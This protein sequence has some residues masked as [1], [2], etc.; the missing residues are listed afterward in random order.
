MITRY[1]CALNGVSLDSLDA[2]IHI[3][4]ITE[5][6]PQQRIVTASSAGHGLHVL[7]RVRERISVKISFLIREYDTVRRR[8]VLQRVFAWANG[9]G[10]LTTGDRPGQQLTVL[11]DTLP[12]MSSLMWLDELTLSFTAYETPFWESVTRSSVTTGASAQLTLPG[13]AD[14]CPVSCTVVNL[15]AEALTALTLQ[16]GDTAMSFEKL[17]LSPGESLMLTAVGRSVTI[18]A[19]GKTA[20]MNRTDE[21][22]D[23]LLALSGETT[24]VSVAADQAVAATF[25]ARGRYL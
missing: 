3:T 7:R 2:A 17:S 20:L 14:D 9:G 6:P 11:C 5:L 19:A 1:S 18:Q 21:S 4:D 16:C 8:E 23:L 15:G 13:T 22:D 10:S 12:G 25:S 24:A